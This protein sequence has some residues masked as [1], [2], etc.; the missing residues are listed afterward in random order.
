MLRG[1]R[2]AVSTIRYQ[3][4]CVIS[5]ALAVIRAP[6]LGAGLHSDIRMLAGRMWPDS[7]LSW[8]GILIPMNQESAPEL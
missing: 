1:A 2:L 6:G 7:R 8:P 3:I 5:A 4:S